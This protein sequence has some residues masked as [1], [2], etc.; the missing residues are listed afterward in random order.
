V[1]LP[2]LDEIGMAQENKSPDDTPQLHEG[3]IHRQGDRHGKG[4]AAETKGDQDQHALQ[5]PRHEVVGLQKTS[6]SRNFKLLPLL[7]Y[8][9]CGEVFRCG[10]MERPND[11]RELGLDPVREA[12][13]RDVL[14]EEVGGEGVEDD[15]DGVDVD[16]D[17]EIG[18]QES[19]GAEVIVR[20][21]RDEWRDECFG[22]SK[23]PTEELPGE[24]EVREAL[25]EDIR[26]GD[27]IG[28]DNEALGREC[29]SKEEGGRERGGTW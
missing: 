15:L 2:P 25:P 7:L 29:E 17:R 18:S 19:G 8:L 6:R 4:R 12:R 10:P 26:G 16:V 1:V 23:C 11:S 21:G 28:G 3:E 14:G 27:L 20:E 9:L 24:V 13:I 5:V 22:E